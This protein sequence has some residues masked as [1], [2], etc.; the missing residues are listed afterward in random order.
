MIG[1]ICECECHR[2]GLEVLHCFSCCALTYQKYM[3]KKGV[4]D[5]KRY[6]ELLLFCEKMLEDHKIIKK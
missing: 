2:D 3:D 6:D 5:K 4:L 1:R